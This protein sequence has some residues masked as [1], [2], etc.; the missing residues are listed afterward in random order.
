MT[1]GATK[2]V[3]LYDPVSQASCALP[4]LPEVRG[5]HT[6]DGPLLCGGNAN[7]HL[8]PIQNCMLFNLGRYT[9]IQL[10]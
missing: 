5:L 8:Q 1:G 6:Q 10:I 3:E 7:T 9:I 2:E 4:A